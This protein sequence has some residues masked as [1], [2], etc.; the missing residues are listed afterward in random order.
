M[1]E[2]RGFDGHK[3]IYGIKLHLAVTTAGFPLSMKISTANKNDGKEAVSLVKPLKER[4]D[5][6]S[7]FADTAYNGDFLVENYKQKIKP[8]VKCPKSN[9]H[10][11][12]VFKKKKAKKYNKTRWVVERS[13]AWLKNFKRLAICTEKNWN[14]Y[15]SNA[16]LAFTVIWLRKDMPNT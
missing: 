10:G 14:T 4:H 13:F 16:W 6:R 3:R 1:S 9:P 5:I 15:L 8:Y 11:H 12:A 2:G 7:T